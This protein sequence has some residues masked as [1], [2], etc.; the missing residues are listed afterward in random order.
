[1][2]YYKKLFE[3]MRSDEKDNFGNLIAEKGQEE[4]FL[5]EKLMEV[6]QD[7]HLDTNI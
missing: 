4:E 5:N 2:G 7:K 1:M 3:Q 6:I